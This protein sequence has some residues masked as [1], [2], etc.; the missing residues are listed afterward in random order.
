VSVDT[1]TKGKNL[2]PYQR[3]AYGG[4]EFLLP[5][6]LF[7]WAADLTVDAKRSILGTRFVVEAGHAHGPG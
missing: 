6:D 3:H 1:N 7:G 4:V 2:D 5:R